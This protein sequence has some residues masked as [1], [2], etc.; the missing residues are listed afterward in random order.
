MSPHLTI[1]I[2][3]LVKTLRTVMQ[4]N[5]SH[6]MWLIIDISLWYRFHS[7]NIDTS[8][9]NAR[10]YALRECGDGNDICD[11]VMTI[12]EI[13]LMVMLIV[14]FI[15]HFAFAMFSYVLEFISGF[16]CLFHN[17]VF[18]SNANDV[19]SAESLSCVLISDKEI[20]VHYCFSVF[21]WRFAG[22]YFCT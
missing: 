1:N 16:S 8:L 2:S 6:T 17:I 12:M 21:S 5:F 20:S 4:I 14:A 10:S 19:F 15:K 18:Q 3:Q 7:N 9:L 11:H 22:I 13:V